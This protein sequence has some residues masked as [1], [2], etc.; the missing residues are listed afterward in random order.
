M[1]FVQGIVDV[2]N[3]SPYFESTATD[4][5]KY[6][7]RLL[8]R[9]SASPDVLRANMYS[10]D[11]RILW[12]SDPAMIGRSFA[13]AP[14]RELA[15][16]LS[17]KLEIHQ[18][19]AGDSHHGK[20]EHSNLQTDTGSFLEIYV[21]IQDRAR[22]KVVGVVELYRAPGLLQDT[23]VSG[24]RIVWAGALGAGV[25]LY[26]ALLPLVRIAESM[27]RK[28]QDQ[29]VEAETIAAVGDL[30][31]AVAH[32]IRNPLAV[33]RTSAE[34]VRDG[35]DAS[36]AREAAS[37][38][39]DQVDRLEHWVRGLLTYVH[40]PSGNADPIA[41]APLVHSCLAQF[42]VEMRRHDIAGSVSFPETLPPVLGDPILLGQV[43]NSLVANAV[44][45][46]PSGGKLALA[47]RRNTP[48]FVVLKISDTGVG[49][50]DEQL[51]NAFRPFYTTKAQGMGIGLP[52]AKRI[53]DRMGA[54]ISLV[55]APGKGTSVEI[56]LPEAM[57]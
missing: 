36:V 25:L 52:L 12:S 27:I 2:E 4:D 39:M 56:S 5:L 38:I 11:R 43:I 28:Q 44:Q 37:D 54:G 17:G 30:G 24:M 7:E 32:G 14:N 18:E 33:I 20:A 49:M 53:L 19:D 47:G 3:A 50:T 55:S 16:A 22:Q 6:L 40:L 8:E 13:N 29:I 31:S 57:R 9:M 26:L 1:Q 41:L 48:G 51:R 23:I 21:P 34:I 35:D 15:A 45:A 42:S 46:M 10:R